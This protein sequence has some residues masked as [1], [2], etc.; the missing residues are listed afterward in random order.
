MTIHCTRSARN[1]LAVLACLC[2]CVFGGMLFYHANILAET[3]IRVRSLLKHLPNGV[4]VCSA[5]GHVLF[6]NEA[7]TALTGFTAADLMK[8]GVEIMMPAD[9]RA[10]HRNGFHKATLRVVHGDETIDSPRQI[11]PVQR[12]DGTMFRALITIGTIPRNGRPEFFAFITPVY[13]H[14]AADLTKEM[15]AEKFEER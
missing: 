12:K 7:V 6:V 3:D 2:A 9:L 8:D 5:D 11:L 1:I 15:P 14:A 4:V 10:S 13:A